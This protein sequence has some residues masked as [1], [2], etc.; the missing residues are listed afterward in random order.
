VKVTIVC[1]SGAVVEVGGVAAPP[2]FSALD[3]WRRCIPRSLWEVARWDAV[4]TAADDYLTDMGSSE[5]VAD[6]EVVY[7]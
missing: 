3:E 2:I 5:T 4:I 7:E 6:V 1:D